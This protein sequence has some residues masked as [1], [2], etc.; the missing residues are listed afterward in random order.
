MGVCH[1]HPECPMTAGYYIGGGMWICWLHALFDPVMTGW[2]A[3]TGQKMVALPR[4]GAR[5]E[6]EPSLSS[7]LSTEIARD[8]P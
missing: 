3:R 8:C 5:K 7:S 6:N 2:V 1:G 4:T